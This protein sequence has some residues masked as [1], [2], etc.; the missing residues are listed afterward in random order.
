MTAPLYAGIDGGG[1]KTAVVVVDG[2]GQEVARNMTTTSNAAVVG[3]EQAAQ[4]LLDA[5]GEAALQAGA[6]LPFAA[7]WF[8]LSGSDRPED[9]AYLTPRLAGVATDLMMT[10]DAE[11]ALAGL[12]GRVGVAIVAGTGSIALGQNAAG[13]KAR[14][15]GWGHIFSDEGS[16][17]D[18]TRR[19]LRAFAAARDGRGP[20]TS[21]TGRI[22][23]RWQITDPFSV[24]TRVYDPSTTKGDL[25]ALSSIVVEE[26]A[27]GDAVAAA[28]MDAAAT[29]LASLGSAVIRRL[30]LGPE[31][32]V[33]FTGGM[34]V[35]VEAYRERVLHALRQEWIVADATLVD[36]PA[37]TAARYLAQM[38]E[39]ALR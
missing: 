4:T 9:H 6:D 18:L 1:T 12:P 24:I 10:N 22:L 13:E 39:G 34:V 33:A 11:L 25:A 8:G 17:Y 19:M 7:A 35:H 5:I 32:A 31:V 21:L 20:E 2:A 29:E 16:G 15:G 37:L 3:H 38:H 28:I 36:D 23:G 27:A 30:S 26:A 14:A